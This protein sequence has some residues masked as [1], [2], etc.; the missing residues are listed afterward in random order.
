MREC[1]TVTHWWLNTT[2]WHRYSSIITVTRYWLNTTDL[3]LLYGLEERNATQ[4]VGSVT[5]TTGSMSLR[6]NS[7]RFVARVREEHAEHAHNK[8]WPEVEFPV[9]VNSR[10]KKSCQRRFLSADLQ[11]RTLIVVRQTLRSVGC[12]FAGFVQLFFFFFLIWN[13]AVQNTKLF[14][15]KSISAE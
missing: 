7:R 1:Y 6:S 4:T 5:W 15:E 8:N 14:T 2:N 9:L 10:K 11:G 3:Q 12:L 13:S